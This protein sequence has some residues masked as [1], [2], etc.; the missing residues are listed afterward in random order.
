MRLLLCLL[1]L[2]FLMGVNMASRVFAQDAGQRDDKRIAARSANDEGER[3]R[4]LGTK[5]SLRKA[6]DKY[7]EALSLWRSVG[8]QAGEA[9]TLTSAAQVFNSLGEKQKALGYFRRAIALWKEVGDGKGQAIALSG[10]GAVYFGLGDHRQALDHLTQSLLL[11]RSL[12]DDG[13]AA[14]RLN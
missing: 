14:K 11:F 12:K 13:G 9:G 10:I 5:E 7:E 3:L 1:S 8:D 4:K 2:T 6:I